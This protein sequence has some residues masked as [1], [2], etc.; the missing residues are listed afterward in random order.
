M[1]I[2][3]NNTPRILAVNAALSWIAL[4]NRIRGSTQ[5]RELRQRMKQHTPSG[6]VIWYDAVTVEGRLQWQDSLTELNAP[7]FDA[8]DGIFVN[9][10]WRVRKRAMVCPHRA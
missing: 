7:F 3:T 5:C 2:L 6:L 10:T 9:Y 4:M 1:N 8:C